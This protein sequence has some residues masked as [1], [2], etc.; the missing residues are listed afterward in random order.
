MRLTGEV[1]NNIG[2]PPGAEALRKLIGLILRV[3]PIGIGAL[4]AAAIGRHG[5]SLFGPLAVFIGGVWLCH[6]V[7]F[8]LYL[9]LMF[10]FTRRSPWRFLRQ[11]APLYS[12]A[13]ATCS[14]LASLVVSM[15]I[16]ERNLKL[17]RGV[18]ALTLPLGAQLNKDGTAITLLGVL[19]FT[20]QAANVRFSFSSLLTAALLALI[21]AGSSGAIP[22]GGLVMALLFVKSFQLPVEIAVIIGG[23]YRLLDM[24]NT[25]INCMAD[26]VG[27]VIVADREAEAAN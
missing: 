25:T 17:P 13:A 11:S 19:L 5:S 2:Q 15:E 16:A 14:S 7:M 3:A 1:R 24:G 10:A 18:Y 26:L 4:T 22:G 8:V 12:T 20:A 27:T 21:L 6:A 23:V 9:A